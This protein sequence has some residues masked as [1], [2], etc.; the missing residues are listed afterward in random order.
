MDFEGK[1]CGVCGKGKLH[2]FTEE[3]TP[4][5]YADAYKCDYAGHVSYPE[6][7]MKAIEAMHRP[8]STRRHVVKVGNSLA[9]PIPA[10]MAKNLGLKAKNLVFVRS[11]GSEI[12]IRPSPA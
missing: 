7:V 6:K 10:E 11:S 1:H 8:A 2:K 12:T 4:G 3:I 9:V 5:V